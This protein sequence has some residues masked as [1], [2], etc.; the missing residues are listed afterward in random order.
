MRILCVCDRGISRSPT[1]AALLSNKG[2]ET[3]A[4]GVDTASKE[5]LA[6]LD[7]WAELI[8][9]TDQRQISCFPE[10][11][12]FLLWVIPDQYVRPHNPLLRIRVLHEIR[13]SKL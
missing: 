9:F 12:E 8:V 10:A 2:H 3:L 11:E 6:M 7:G 1:I 13:D 4:V 5:T